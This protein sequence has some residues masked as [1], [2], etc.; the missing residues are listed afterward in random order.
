MVSYKK[1]GVSLALFTAAT[2]ANSQTTPSIF[3]TPEYFANWGLQYTYAADAW[4]LG[5]TGKGVRI[6]IAD[7][8]AQLSHPEFVGRIL[9]S[10]QQAPFPNPEFP[11][12]PEH[13][14]HVMGVAA[15]ARDGLG[16]VGVAHDASI[17]HVVVVAKTGYPLTNN[18]TQQLIDAKVSVMNGSFG[19]PATPWPLTPLG[20]SDGSLN[21]NYQIVNFQFLS[22]SQV[23]SYVSEI[24]KLADADVVMVFSAGNQ[25][26]SFLQPLAAKVPAGHSIIPLIK[27]ANT[28]LGYTSNPADAVYRIYTDAADRNNPSTWDS[29]QLPFSDIDAT[30][31]SSAAGT[32]IAVTAADI[33]P[34]TGAVILANFSNQ[35]GLAADWCITAPGVAIYSTVP[36][37]TYA[38][39]EKWSGTSMAAPFVAGAAA[40]LR[41][42]FPYMTAR[43]I[44]EVLLTTATE[45][46]NQNSES[47]RDF[48]HGLI[49]IGRAVKGP[50]EFGHPSLIPGNSSIFAPIFAVD[51]KGYDSVWSNDI[52]GIGGFS[53]AGKGIL[54]LTGLN[55]YTGDTTITGGVLRVDGS[56]ASSNLSVTS[57][58]TLQGIGTVGNTSM[59]GI[60]SPGNSVGTLTVSGDL[61]LLAGSVYQYEIDA[62]QKSD[63]VSV[64]GRA[65]IDS[66]AIF[67]LSAEDG[68]YLN[69][70]Y[71][72]LQANSLIGT[73]FL[74]N[75]TFINLDFMPSSDNLGLV[76]QR[77]SVPMASFAQ[78]NNQRAVAK[79]IDAQSSGDEPFN[80]VLLNDNPS[81]L[82]NLYQGWS[83]EIY[84][85]NQA[86]L[87]YNSRLLAQ[88]MNWRLQDSWLSNSSTTRLQRV[89]QTNADTTV[90]AQAYGN[91]DTFSAN[92]DAK[93]ATSNSGGLI[94][95]VDHALTTNFRLGGGFSA[96]TTNTSVASSSANT[97][98]YHVML[99]STYDKNRLR[100]NSGVVQSWYSANMRRTLPL[101]DRGNAKGTV[102]SR[103]T[104]LFA[105]LSSPITLSQ[106]QDHHTTIAPF[107]QVS[108]IWL[109]TSKFSESGAEAG[110]TGFVT[111]ANTGFGTLGAR[112]SHQWKTD[113][114]NWQVGLSAGWQRAWGD[115]S[116][117]TTLAFATGPGFTVNA[118]PIARNSAVVEVGIGASLGQS[119][120]FNLVYSA[121]LSGQ[122]RGQLLQAQLQQSF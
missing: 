96:S 44:I 17:A 2:I 67:K 1:A 57:G 7:D 29:N 64:T 42:A 78:T 40:V 89:G 98:G 69:R 68:V 38:G 75:Y 90:W 33:D 107:G 100:L 92:A 65:V 58:A 102:D 30:D 45:I 101:D 79:A 87:I 121:T 46:N 112:L 86:A 66:G 105:D 28:A 85:A 113:K 20:S 111:N 71:P 36:M 76:V 60:L 49:N 26:S 5:F 24:K 70:L 18:W 50:I 80:D 22:G 55:T 51:T 120:R 23:G 81:Q 19:P 47:I 103:S 39:G 122:S 115:L 34:N 43:Q 72:V 73:K 95:G 109:Q 83:G 104:Q 52:S 16:M 116:P 6:G 15:A 9:G 8:Q 11:N 94:L 82:P 3:Y 119:S 59:A 62:N 91:W 13:G 77:N 118:A 114:N 41:Q 56:I 108:Q 99:Y 27:P 53:K 10:S 14:T 21:P 63:F 37:D 54:V 35:C 88:V 110:L 25:R 48:G 117:T 31:F 4:A 61:D 74:T 93:K 84:S 106:L 12:F 97:N 32:L